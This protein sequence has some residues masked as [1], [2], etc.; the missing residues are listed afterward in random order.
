[1]FGMNKVNCG[2]KRKQRKCIGRI[3]YSSLALGERY[4]LRM[5]LNVVKGVFGFEELMTVNKRVCVTF[6]EACFGYGLLHDDKEWSYA[7]AEASLWALGPQ[8]RDIFVTMLIFC[9]VNRPLKHWEESW[10]TL[11]EDILAK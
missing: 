8:L 1:M 9:S 6:K 11:S 3:V 7:I 10:Q 4:Y 5:L 2:K